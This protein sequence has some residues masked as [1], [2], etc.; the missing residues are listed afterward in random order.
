MDKDYRH[1]AQ[2]PVVCVRQRGGGN[3]SVSGLG[4]GVARVRSAHPLGVFLT[5]G[6]VVVGSRHGPNIFRHIRVSKSV[7]CIYSGPSSRAAS[8]LDRSHYSVSNPCPHLQ[9]NRA[10]GRGTGR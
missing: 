5:H 9:K 3:R 1:T 2:E 4:P 8:V 6:G 10:G 7:L